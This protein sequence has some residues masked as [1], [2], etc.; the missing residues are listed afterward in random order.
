MHLILDVPWK[1]W[2]NKNQSCDGNKDG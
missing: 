1:K 2:N